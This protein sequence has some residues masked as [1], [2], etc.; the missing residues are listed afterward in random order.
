MVFQQFIDVLIFS[1]FNFVDLDLLSQFQ[2]F[3]EL[4]ILSFVSLNQVYSIFIKLAFQ[5]RNFK[6]KVLLLSFD[7]SGVSD[8]VAN[9]LILVLLFV[10]DHVLLIVSVVLLLLV[11]ELG[12]LVSDLLLV[13]AVLVLQ[14]LDLL[15][16]D[17]DLGLVLLL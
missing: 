9:V 3:L 10:F 17:L 6:I 4:F 12:G 16:V 1:F 14:M 7:R 5:F 2:F 8:L 13:V 11:H 15:L